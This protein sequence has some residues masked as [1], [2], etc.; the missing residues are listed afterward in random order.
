MAKIA[1]RVIAAVVVLL[2]GGIA[3]L[4]L[5]AP[6]SNTDKARLDAIIVLGYP[7]QAD[8]SPE[9]EMRARVLESVR[10]YKAGV[11]PRIIMTGGPA[12][13]AFVEADVM[14]KLAAANGVPQSALVRERR[15]GN[16]IENA[17]YSVEIMQA[18]GWQSAEVITTPAHVPR[19]GVLFS[20]YP[21]QWRTHTA[22]WPPEYGAF[23]RVVRYIYEAQATARLRLTGPPG[24][25]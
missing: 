14:A 20:V 23:D 7:A 5:T 12:H 22:P 21:I 10:E 1:R 18:Q 8:G 13:N 6:G 17:R 24:P 15:A 16:T 19:S 9:P 4:Y 2:F 25:R 11:A 3:T